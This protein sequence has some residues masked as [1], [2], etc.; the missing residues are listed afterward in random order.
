MRIARVDDAFDL[1]RG[2]MPVRDEGLRQDGTIS[3]HGRRDRGH[4]GGLDKCGRVQRCAVDPD[5]LQVIG[6]INRVLQRALGFTPGFRQVVERDRLDVAERMPRTFL[7]ERTGFLAGGIAQG[8]QVRTRRA[9]RNRQRRTS[10]AGRG[11]A[12]LRA[13]SQN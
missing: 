8:M 9:G 7:G 10:R 2:K 13:V 11:A 12:A 6:L 5:R 1:R 3:R 4:G